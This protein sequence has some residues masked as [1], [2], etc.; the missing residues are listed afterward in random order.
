MFGAVPAVLEVALQLRDEM[1]AR[2]AKWPAVQQFGDVL[3]QLAPQLRHYAH[4]VSAFPHASATLQTA[5]R[6]NPPLY[7]EFLKVRACMLLAL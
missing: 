3:V 7:A 4:Y 5:R 1:A 6:R 2:L